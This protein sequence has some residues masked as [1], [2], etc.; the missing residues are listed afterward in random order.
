MELDPAT[1]TELGR[2]KSSEVNEGHWES[3]LEGKKAGKGRGRTSKIVESKE[4]DHA[5]L[6]PRRGRVMK[7][8][9]DFLSRPA[10][11]HYSPVR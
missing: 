7:K 4:P 8:K 6:G 2:D 1:A 9:I 5:N 3:K 10:N 11:N